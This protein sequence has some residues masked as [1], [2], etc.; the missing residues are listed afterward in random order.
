MMR[1]LI[2]AAIRANAER[3]K[4]QLIPWV[5]QVRD[6]FHMPGLHHVH[7]GISECTQLIEAIDRYR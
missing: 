1:R 6:G 5:E 3:T 4:E 2:L 7:H